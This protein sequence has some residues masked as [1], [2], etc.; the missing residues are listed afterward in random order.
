MTAGANVDL[1]G[2]EG[3]QHFTEPPPRF[4][5]ATLVKTLEELGIGRPSTYAPIIETLLSRDYVRREE[6]RL[7][8][9]ELGAVVVDLLKEFFPEIVDVQ[10]TADMEEQLDQIE[11]GDRSWREVLERFYGGFR[12]E[13][14]AA[15]KSAERVE[16][17]EE[18]TDE[19][20]DRCQRPMVIK[21]GRF[22]RFLACSGYPECQNTRPFLEKT[23][24]DCPVCGRPVVV[25]RSKRGR[26]F[27][28]CSGYPECTFVSWHRP[29][30]RR[31]PRC[32][33]F[34]AERRR[35]QRE[36]FA[37]VREGCGYVEEKAQ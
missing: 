28:G 36:A 33:A 20:C 18:T 11:A 27:Y 2:V 34:L 6:R 24:A 35:G 21:H 7:R 30:D 8:P 3:T 9:T 32:G 22:G 15:E 13:L 14:E 1:R 5:E 17:A 4:T 23:G 37:C 12:V 16:L 25:R 26:I 10:F 29:S 19:V 31:C